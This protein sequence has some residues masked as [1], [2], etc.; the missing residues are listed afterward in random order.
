MDKLQLLKRLI[1]GFLPIIVFIVVDEI[2]GTIYGLIVAITIGIIE[3][4]IG[5]IK[6]RKLERF[7]L[8]DVG[9]II[10]LGAV[11]I[12]LDNDLFF[13]LKPGIVSLLMTGLIGYSAFSK[14]NLMLQMTQRYMKNLSMNPYHLWMMQQSMK[15]IF[16]LLLIYSIATLASSFIDNKAIWSF[17]GTGGL[18]VVMAVFFVY[19]WL[20]KKRLNKQYSHEEWLP[21]VNDKGKVLGSAPRSVVH[22]KSFLLHPVVHL[23]VIDKGKLLLQKRPSHKLI[24]PNKWDTAVGGHVAAGESIETSLQR[25]TQEEIGLTQFKAKSIG[26]YSW[27]SE[28]ET[29]LVFCFMTNHKGPF[30]FAK[31]EVDEVRFWTPE[32]INDNIG[33]GI[34]TPN[35][36]YEYNTFKHLLHS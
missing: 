36:E 16:W 18:V 5:Y 33:K 35:F 26:Q 12:L 25:E 20:S 29:E 7:V 28:V 8:F 4:V 27:K 22:S 19:E 1:P 9:L 10:A 2:W 32:E 3:L 11:S 6:I 13:K 14:H 15:R 30:N 23:H 21:L 34:F 17:M 31:N 24:Q